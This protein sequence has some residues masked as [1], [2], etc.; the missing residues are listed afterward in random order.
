[1]SCEPRQPSSLATLLAAQ[2]PEEDGLLS[3]TAAALRSWEG[4]IGGAL[5]KFEWVIGRPV[6]APSHP[7]APRRSRLV[8]EVLERQEPSPKVCRARP[9]PLPIGTQEGA[10]VSTRMYDMFA[11]IHDSD[12]ASAGRSRHSSRS[13]SG[14]ARRRYM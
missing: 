5:E 7:G 10:S 8:R 14:Q 9:R 3:G 2:L 4:R 12:E 13:A 6:E 11:A 1:M